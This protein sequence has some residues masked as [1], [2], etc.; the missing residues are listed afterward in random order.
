[1]ESKLDGVTRNR[2]INEQTAKD[3]DNLGMPCLSNL[4]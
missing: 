4:H 1:M 3:L 2:L